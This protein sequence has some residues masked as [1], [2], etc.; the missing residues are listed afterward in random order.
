MHGPRAEGDLA[1]AARCAAVQQR[2]VA[3][4]A[5]VESDRGDGLARD[6]DLAVVARGVLGDRR[7]GGEQA[8]RGLRAYAA[9]AKV[10]DRVPV[11]PVRARR[12]DEA[13]QAGAEHAGR[14]HGGDRDDAARQGGPDGHGGP[15]PAGLERQPHADA[16][17]HRPGPAQQRGQPR[18]SSPRRTGLGDAEGPGGLGGGAPGGGAEEQEREQRDRGRPGTEDGQVDLE[19][20]R[21]LDGP[22]GADRHQRRGRD[23]D[24]DRE[25]RAG[26]SDDGEPCQGQRDQGT[27]GRA[28]GPQHRELRRFQGELPGEQLDEHGERDQACQGGEGREGDGLRA[29]GLLEGGH[30]VGLADHVA[31]AEGSRM[32]VRALVR[33]GQG[34]GG[35][36]EL[37]HP[38]VRFEADRGQHAVAERSGER[39][40]C[41]RRGDEDRGRA[42]AAVREIHLRVEGDDGGHQEGEGDGLGEVGR[43]R[44]RVVGHAEHAHP[45]TRAQVLRGGHRLVRPS[46]G[47]PRHCRT[48]D[49]R[50]SWPGP[51][52][53]PTPRRGLR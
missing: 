20:G 17:G 24:G 2:E 18:R 34:T 48:G 47:R 26:D 46:P 29:G 22:G 41:E 1:V 51:P 45:V 40:R 31:P 49:R 4:A 9:E 8:A 38:C 10:G 44:H 28:E 33:D 16:A 39:R 12:A 42:V 3:A 50:E 15:A 7:R 35:G 23:G 27:A 25:E 11:L 19:A 21:G 14:D 13:D 36:D 6:R 52:A 32:G 53:C 30:L 5:I 37:L 43:A